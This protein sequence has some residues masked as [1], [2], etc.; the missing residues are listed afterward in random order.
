MNPCGSRPSSVAASAAPAIDAA[1]SR[2][3]SILPEQPYHAAWAS[4]APQA[5]CEDEEAGGACHTM[6]YGSTLAGAPPTATGTH[7]L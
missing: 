1:A 7:K 5:R 3:H 2:V 4:A 6:S